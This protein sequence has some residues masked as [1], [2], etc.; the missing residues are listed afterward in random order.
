VAYGLPAA[1]VASPWYLKNWLWLGS[2]IW[3]F[4]ASGVPDEGGYFARHMNT[5]RDLLGYLLLPLRLYV[6][7][8]VE[9]PAAIPALAFLVIPAYLLVRR[10]WIATALLALAGLHFVVWSQGI[11]TVRYLFP[12]FPALSLAAAF[13]VSQGMAAG[14]SS[15]RSAGPVLVVLSAAL[16][17][18]A[19]IVSFGLQQP[20]PQLVGLE[21]REAYLARAIHDYPAIEHLNDR[22]EQVGR[23]LVIGDAR[24]YHHRSSVLVDQSLGVAAELMP[25]D[26]P[27]EALR[28]LRAS[29]VTHVYVSQGHLSW[30]AL[31]DPERRV[32]AWWSA[33]Q[34]AA[35][36]FL[37]PE[38][39]HDVATVYR[40]ADAV[41]ERSRP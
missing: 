27:A 34:A 35:P 36:T 31:F 21:S 3:P 17:L 16:G 33:F 19:S 38:F 7:G 25:L 23:V 41:A 39:S 1:I 13:V 26:H 20:L 2:P 22:P 6:G 8:T 32:M 12:I 11:Q 24:V 40:V 14:H 5:G 28:R 30:L 29:G 15:V 37:V 4:L 18:G 10:Q 9:L